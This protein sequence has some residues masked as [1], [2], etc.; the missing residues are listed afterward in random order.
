MD[1]IKTADIVYFSGTGGT[2]KVALALE[3]ELIK[4]NITVNTYELKGEFKEEIQGDLLI[5]LFPVYAANAPKSIDEWVKAAAFGKGKK[6]A[7]ISV[8][9]GGEMIFNTACRLSTI[10]SLAKNGYDVFYEEMFVM[11]TNCLMANSDEL[12]AMLLNVL[13]QKAHKAV[14][15]IITG[16]LHTKKPLIIDRLITK[17]MLIEKYASKLFGKHLTANDD[18]SGCGLCADNCP[19]NNIIMKN[20][21]PVFNGSCVI[22]LKCIYSCPQKAIMS[23]Y[24]KSFIIKEGFNINA[25]EEKAKS[26]K[27]YQ[28]AKEAAKGFLYK[29]V[30]EYLEIEGY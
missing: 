20:Q 15:Q 7:V 21:K 9:G 19:R 12:N 22:C 2:A 23:K 27:N 16:N 28:P 17:V 26:I 11:P 8:S 30:R 6:T 1:G 18:C 29:G 10:K 4:N 3:K 25:I 5:I 13:P 24:I 14:R